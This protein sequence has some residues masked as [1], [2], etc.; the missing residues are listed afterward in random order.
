MA[1]LAIFFVDGSGFCKQR[2]LNRRDG[3]DAKRFSLRLHPIKSPKQVN[4]RRATRCE[5]IDGLGQLLVKRCGIRTIL[6]A[7]AN[8]ISRG[9]ANRWGTADSQL[10]DCF[11]N[12]FN[13]STLDLFEFDRQQRLVNQH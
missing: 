8:T 10:F 4:S 12:L 6:N 1:H 3:I 7:D 2:R 13:R 9:D 11:P 5:V